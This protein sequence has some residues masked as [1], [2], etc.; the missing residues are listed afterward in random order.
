MSIS[1]E[2][3]A[4][5]S[6]YGPLR[7]RE[8]CRNSTGKPRRARRSFRDLRRPTPRCSEPVRDNGHKPETRQV[9]ACHVLCVLYRARSPPPIA[10]RDC[11]SIRGRELA[12]LD[13]YSL[14]DWPKVLQSALSWY[15]AL[16]LT[17]DVE[18][19]NVRPKRSTCAGRGRAFPW[20]ELYAPN[21]DQALQFYVDA[22]GFGITEMDMGTGSMYKMLTVDGKAVAGSMDTNSP[23]MQGV[24]PHRPYSCRSM[25]STHGSRSAWSLGRRW[26][27]RSWRCRRS[28]E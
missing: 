23:D 6:R 11:P 5:G 9:D 3:G 7:Q 10:N 24:P 2:S 8:G 25:T 18:Y 16:I 15:L 4:L 26:W 27:F 12:D 21:I 19:E 14:W 13:L 1:L 28:A 22:L 17:S 20:H